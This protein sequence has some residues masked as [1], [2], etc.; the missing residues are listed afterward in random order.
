MILPTTG[1][2]V[3]SGNANTRASSVHHY[4]NKKMYPLYIIRDLST[5]VEKT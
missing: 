5:S 3:L 4:S 2:K 1:F